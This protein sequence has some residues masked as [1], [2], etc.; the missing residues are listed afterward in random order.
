M[1]VRWKPL[2]ILSGLFFVVAVVGVVTMAW[3]LMPRS[4]EA[5]LKQARS[6]RSAG[7]F[8]DAEI[9]YKQAL[10]LEPK[11]A[12]IHEEFAG[13]YAEWSAEAATDRREALHAERYDH[14]VKAVKFDKSLKS[15]RVA[16]LE[17]AL[18]HDLAAD[19][20]YWAGELL[21]VDP[22]HPDAHYVLA[23]EELEGRSPNIP[24]VKRHLKVLEER[25]APPIRRALL[26]GRLAQASGDEAGLRRVVEE[27][28]SIEVAA[29]AA[30]ADRIAQVRLEALAVQSMKDQE[31]LERRVEALLARVSELVDGPEVPPAR[32]ARLSQL[33]EQ[34]Q[35]ALKASGTG[36]GRSEDRPVRE[37]VVERLERALESMFQKALESGREA[38]LQVYLTYANHL[39]YRQEHARCLQVVE[40]AL[41]RP[42]ATRPANSIQ[43]LGLHAVAVEVALGRQD[44]EQ[45]YQ[46]AE[47][48]IRALLAASEPRFRGLGH[49]FQ[50]AVDLE[51]SGLIQAASRP[52]AGEAAAGEPGE[53][54]VRAAQAK[55]RASA[56]HHLKQAAELLPFVPEAQAR[57]G[58][59]LVLTQEQG[60]GRQYL[61]NAL[62]G[63][64]LDP[65]YQFWAAWTILQAGYPEEAEPVVE[66]LF[67]Q[68][69]QGAI[70][71]E[72]EGTLHQIRGE[73]YQA[74]RRPG[75]LERA[76]AEFEKAK[77]GGT[78]TAPGVLL[79][80]A[81]IDMQLGRFDEAQA[82]ID[83][84]RRSG[85]G[86][87]AAEN[88][89]ILILED[90]G[91]KE[92]AR[93][94]LRAARQRYP[95][96]PEL[97]GLEAALLVKD[98]RPEDAEKT[99]AEYLRH[100]PDHVTLTLMRAEVLA[101]NLKRP[102]EARAILLELAD[103]CENSSP[104]VQL[105]QLEMERGDLEAAEKAIAAIRSRWKEAAA[106][107][108]LDGQLALK[109]GNLTAAAD[110]FA[111][112]LRKDPDNKIVQFWKAQIDSRTGSIADAARTLEELVR[113]QP[114]KEVDHGVSLMTAAQSALANLSL[115]KGDVDDAIRRFEELRRSSETGTLTKPDRWQLIT[116]Y[117]AKGQWNTAR[118]ELAAI[119][120]DPVNP[121]SE[122]ERVRGANLYRQ[123]DE[124][125]A[126]LAQLDYVLKV[127]PAHPAAVVTRS[128]IHLKQANHAEARAILRRAIDRSQDQGAKPP[129]VL[130][131][132]L[133][134]VEN[135]APPAESA[136][137]RARGAL[138]EGLA[139][140]PHSIE[141]V[142][143]EYLVL[144]ASGD[145]QAA[146]AFVES[147][148]ESEPKGPFRRMLV[149]IYRER[150][151][152][153]KAESLLRDL[154]QETPD[155]PNLA[156]ALVQVVSL[157]AAQAV[158]LGEADRSRDLDQRTMA[159]IRQYRERFPSHPAFL[160]AECDVAVRAGDFPR[161]LTLTQELDQV[162]KASTLG[163]MLRARIFAIQGKPRDAARAYEEALE[164]NPAQNDIR[165]LLGQTLLELGEYEEVLRQARRIQQTDRDRVD[166]LLLEARALAESG[167]AGP[168]RESSLTAAVDRLQTAIARAPRLAEAYHSLASI[169][170][171]RGRREEA[172][173]V[174]TK[175][176]EANPDD[177]ATI[178]RLLELTAGPGDQGQSPSPADLDQVRA[179]VAELSARDGKGALVL[180]AAVGL[181]KA[182]QLEMALPLA[183]KA[184]TMLESPTAHL[185]L[186]DLLLSIAESRNDSAALPLLERAVEQYDRVL[187]LVPNSV[188]AINNKAWV[189][190]THLGRSPQALELATG[191]LNRVDP[192]KLPGE[193]FDT[194][195]FIQEGMGQLQDA[196]Q[197]Y[198]QGLKRA[199]DHPMLNY[200]YGRLIAADTERASRAKGYLARAL[201]GRDQ[202]SPAMAEEADRILRQLGPGIKGN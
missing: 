175:C 71:R 21:K 105:A 13:L 50:G 104:L 187:K 185:N 36:T 72:L 26:R 165:L 63:G 37:A 121:P 83:Q 116:A 58:V 113:N 145:P 173:A 67:R 153:S 96:A 127:N 132:M 49:L 84:L 200:H 8:A 192:A 86:G 157:Q 29:G 90:R 27:A 94:T 140:Q 1:T 17:L 10:Q 108:I 158:A 81:Q 171:K 151:E 79:R 61:Q 60:L 118:R 55:S 73:I 40:E 107:D 188:E 42:A 148:A 53:A 149:E 177:T 150:L 131:L 9:H 18:E 89:A 32:V 111:A 201:A 194:L 82:R 78:G 28:S 103:R 184:A 128:Y 7:R 109:R 30:T 100:D 87:A 56:L 142:Q 38:D 133:A 122:D 48:H 182:G 117:A 101:E 20:V 6:A 198:L 16:L 80:Q 15:P 97:I 154:V 180:A 114:T 170:L 22:E 74:R 106:S 91:R 41:G 25:Q 35:R 169:E 160:Q 144:A 46:R 62:R 139:V 197:S 5:V 92:E 99:L 162:A 102:D 163:P 11:N 146:V 119:L 51:R 189:L 4:A 33:L 138:E 152:Y 31:G 178:A 186:G 183:E 179:L 181:H 2:L 155:D 54:A 199:P 168:Q 43:V 112:A 136:A 66:S 143:A 123:H 167:P 147:R 64:N 126:A 156:A 39:R 135:E 172:R 193:F 110:H 68:L 174:L 93:A 125:A 75:D 23:I 195:G 69:A 44:D 164:R 124:H 77:A 196:E 176:L 129:A 70:P 95:R 19:S 137:Q 24:E 52:R 88:L 65:Q 120:N 3:T 159:L 202:L 34:T 47:P 191:L 59:A 85:Q 161:A 134:A 130:F 45:R 190:H 98:Q 141:L 76:A 57:Y 14:L 12:R 166:A 115:Q